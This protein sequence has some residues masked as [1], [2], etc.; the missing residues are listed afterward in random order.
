MEE[1]R[2]L[3]VQYSQIYE[4]N[5][6]LEEENGRLRK[7]LKQLKDSLSVLAQYGAV[8]D[9]DTAVALE[10]AVNPSGHSEQQTAVGV[11]SS[12]HETSGNSPSQGQGF[13]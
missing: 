2:V 10:E 13:T 9:T 4:K 5:L 11:T 12:G 7:E 1:N 3:K 6:K 8:G